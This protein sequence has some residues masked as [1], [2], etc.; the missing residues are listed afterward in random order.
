MVWL[1]QAYFGG[2]YFIARIPLFFVLMAVE[3]AAAQG[4]SNLTIGGQYNLGTCVVGRQLAPHERTL[5]PL[6]PAICSSADTMVSIES[7]SLGLVL[8]RFINVAEPYERIYNLSA[9]TVL[10]DWWEGWLLQGWGLVVGALSYDFV[11]YWWHRASKL[12]HWIDNSPLHRSSANEWSLDRW[13]CCGQV[14]R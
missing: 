14:T 6:L 5:S 3:E 13:W 12:N 10:P 2:D 7:G 9:R 8:G 1:G 4:N 11:Y